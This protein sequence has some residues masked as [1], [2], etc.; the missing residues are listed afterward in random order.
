[1]G[2]TASELLRDLVR[3]WAYGESEL[4]GPDHGYAQARSMAAQLAHA[5]LKRALGE[6]PPSHGEAAEMLRGYFGELAGARRRA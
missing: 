6:L 1:M 3:R 4:S 5:A 2:I